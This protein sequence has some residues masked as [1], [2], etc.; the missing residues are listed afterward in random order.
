M[1]ASMFKVANIAVDFLRPKKLCQTGSV[2]SR[3]LTHKKPFTQGDQKPG[4]KGPILRF[5]MEI[6][7]PGEGAPGTS[8][9]AARWAGSYWSCMYEMR[10]CRDSGVSLS[11]TNR[12]IC[13]PFWESAAFSSSL[14]NFLTL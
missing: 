11:C 3:H 14:T 5:K 12:V 4:D 7:K 9:G 8:F 1:D 13:P 10:A 2:R 6:S